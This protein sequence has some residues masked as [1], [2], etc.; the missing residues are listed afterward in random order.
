[1]VDTNKKGL[2][3]NNDFSHR[4]HPMVWSPSLYPVR[5]QA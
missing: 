2:H 3:S 4:H 5:Q 1:L